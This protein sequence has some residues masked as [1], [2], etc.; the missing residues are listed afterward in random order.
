MH[1]A[2][3]KSLASWFSRG[4][5]SRIWTQVHGRV[6]IIIIFISIMAYCIFISFPFIHI[7]S[8]YFDALVISYIFYRL[9]VN[10]E[11]IIQCS[12]STLE[13]SMFKN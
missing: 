2:L 1:D 11:H 10:I 12:T 8:L 6:L 13:P 3:K 9:N 7:G 4:K 5:N